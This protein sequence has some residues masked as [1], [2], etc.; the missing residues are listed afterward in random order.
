MTASGT[1]V[2]F[3]GYSGLEAWIGSEAGWLGTWG[4]GKPI[5]GCAGLGLSPARFLRGYYIC[6]RLRWSSSSRRFLIARYVELGVWMVWTW[7]LGL[8]G[9]LLDSGNLPTWVLLSVSDRDFRL[10]TT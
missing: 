4:P 3:L 2:D 5:R 10:T 1:V 8:R 9:M 7:T 6:A